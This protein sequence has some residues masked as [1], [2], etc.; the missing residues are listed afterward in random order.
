MLRRAETAH[1]LIFALLAFAG[2]VG[3]SRAKADPIPLSPTAQA[4]GAVLSSSYGIEFVTIGAAGNAP[5]NPPEWQGFSD[6]WGRGSVG[7]DYR[8][9]RDE[10]STAQW[11][12]FFNAWGYVSATQ[13]AIPHVQLPGRWG[14]TAAANPYGAGQ[15]FAV[16]PGRDNW[17]VGGVDWRTCAI[18]CNWLHNNEALTRDAFM[19]GAYDVSTFGYVGGGNVFTDQFAHNPG[20]RF[21]IPTWDEWLKAGHYDPNRNG[22]GQGGWWTYS[23][24]S[25]TAPVGG[26]PSF[27]GG[28][29]QANFGFDTDARLEY[30]V[31]LGSYPNFQSPW[32]LLDMSGMT[33]EWT[34]DV[35]T[36]GAVNRRRIE[37]SYWSSSSGNVNA[38][39]L[40]ALGGTDYPND[41]FL[42]WGFRIAAAVPAPGVG[43]ILVLSRLVMQRRQRK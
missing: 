24:T 25:D 6:A 42:G 29:G 13:G 2:E 5:W 22:P 30:Q 17:G 39:R 28:S 26:L 11:T 33:A 34:E 4:S 15:G 8:I 3:V 1:I 27:M 16:T 41:P 43:G 40:W 23:I 32:G 9:S 38:D 35:Q 20:A 14:A 21:W 31:P 18:F 12:R 10:V 36:I 7:Y 19:N 37:G